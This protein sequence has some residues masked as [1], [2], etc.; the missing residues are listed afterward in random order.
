VNNE[1]SPEEFL[2]VPH[3]AVHRRDAELHTC[4]GF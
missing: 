1:K 3:N 4:S 2:P